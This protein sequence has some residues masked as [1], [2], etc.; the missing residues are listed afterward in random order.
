MLEDP[1]DWYSKNTPRAHARHAKSGVPP[2]LAA[3]W[4]SEY[5]QLARKVGSLPSLVMVI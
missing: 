2:P 3:S 4:N 1:K 5:E